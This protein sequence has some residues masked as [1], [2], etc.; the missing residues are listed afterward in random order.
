MKT[1]EARGKFNIGK[2]IDE[3][4]EE[5]KAKKAFGHWEL[6]SE[7]LPRGES[8]FCFTIFVELKIRFYVAI[9]WQIEVRTQCLETKSDWH[10]IFQKKLNFIARGREAAT[11]KITAF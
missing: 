7:V 2:S 8:K 11:K 4:S 5:V 3:R 1:R 6:D 9:K 10:Q